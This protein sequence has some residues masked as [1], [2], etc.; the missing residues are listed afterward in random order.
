MEK[1]RK[2][3]WELKLAIK[4]NYLKYLSEVT[5]WQGLSGS[6][7][8]TMQQ[9]R[10]KMLLTHAYFHVPYYHAILHEAMVVNENGQVNLDNFHRIPFLTKEIIR[11]RFSDL[12]A[13][14]INTRKWYENTSGG[15][16]GEPV[17]FI[18]DKYYGEWSAA[19]TMLCDSWTGYTT[20]QR[21]IILWGSERDLFLGRETKKIRFG[22]WLKNEI[23]LNSFR[24]TPE[25]MRS[26]VKKINES[27]PVQILAYAE[28]IY[29][30]SRFIER[31]GLSVYSPRAIMTSAGT[32]YPHM[33]EVIEKVFR[34]PVFNRYGSREVGNIACECDK[35]EGLHLFAP[36]HYAEILKRDGS[37]ADRNEAGEIVITSL[38]NYAMPLIRYRIGDMGIWS[39]SKCSCG[40]NWPLLMQVTGRTTDTFLRKDGTQVHG[41]YF[42]HLFYFQ[43]WV[44]KFQ[45][46]QESYN[47]IKVLIVL[48]ENTENVVEQYSERLNE[49][50]E[51]IHLVMGNDCKVDFENV[52]DV[53][54]TA[55]GKYRY[56]ISKV[57]R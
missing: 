34:S 21:K 24:M 10:L 29:E 52:E 9:D 49:I 28:S 16:T 56:T 18:Q 5:H 14:D 54:P 8:Q 3:L 23:W 2:I 48:R 6:Q 12:K 4:G 17:R 30:L 57:K 11:A 39:K 50:T 32:L 19:I 42:T 33:R 13:N 26:Y 38:I 15:S 40:R 25:H 47:H 43:D 53:L 51:K 1:I 7:L 27:N 37:F 35:H 44:K 55:S 20:G 46:I 36:I 22:R 45:I 31:E 41:E